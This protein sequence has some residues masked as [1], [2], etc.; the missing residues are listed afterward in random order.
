MEKKNKR[1][2]KEDK[3]NETKSNKYKHLQFQE[4]GMNIVE[5]EFIMERNKLLTEKKYT[6]EN[7]KLINR[8]YNSVITL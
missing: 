6:V 4:N 7:A 1:N 2:V 3:R 5:I 8:Y